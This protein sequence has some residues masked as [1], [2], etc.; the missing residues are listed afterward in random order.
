MNSKLVLA[1]MIAVICVAVTHGTPAPAPAPTRNKRSFSWLPSFLGGQPAAEEPTILEDD[2]APVA[3]NRIENIPVGQYPDA[4][5]IGPIIS[6]GRII[7]NQMHYPIWRI[8][9]YQ[10]LDARPLPIHLVQGGA[11][12]V[13]AQF[14]QVNQQIQSGSQQ[15]QITPPTSENRLPPSTVEKIES[16]L[17]PELIQM[18][19]SYGV[20]DFSNVPSLESAMDLLGTQT[21]EETIAAIKEFAATQE[22]RDLIRQFV[23]GQQ[24]DNEAA[25]SENVETVVAPESVDSTKAVANIDQEAAASQDAS[26]TQ[27]VAVTQDANAQAVKNYENMYASGSSPMYQYLLPWNQAELIAQYPNLGNQGETTNQFPLLGRLA[28]LGTEP[29]K[30]EAQSEDEE[31]E[32]ETTTPASFFGRVRQWT[33]FLNPFTGRQEIPIPPSEN[34]SKDAIATPVSANDE[35]ITN[36]NT[37]PIPE[38]PELPSLPSLPGAEQSPPE[39]PNVHIPIRY[40]PP[41]LSNGAIPRVGGPYV[42]VKLPLDGFN[43]TPQY[44]IE[45]Q[46]LNHARNQLQRQIIPGQVPIA[47]YHQVFYYPEGVQRPV[48]VYHR[49]ATTHVQPTFQQQP[50][51]VPAN[52]AP[53]NEAPVEVPT[54]VGAGQP[55]DFH[56][57]IYPEVSRQS[58]PS[59]PATPIETPKEQNVAPVQ[60][61]QSN[62]NGQPISSNLQVPQ[63]QPTQ[64]RTNPI[65][66][67]LPVNGQIQHVGQLPLVPSAN[68]EVFA[69]APR[70][71]DSYG[72]PAVPF[73]YFHDGK[74][75]TFWVS[76]QS[77]SAHIH[78]EYEVQPSA[79]GTVEYKVSADGQPQTED[80][81]NEE[82]VEEAEQQENEQEEQQPEEEQQQQVEEIDERSNDNAEITP[83][84]NQNNEELEQ[85]KAIDIAET[86]EEQEVEENVKTE[87]EVAVQQTTT[88]TESTIYNS[89]RPKVKK[90]IKKPIDKNVATPQNNRFIRH[91]TDLSNNGNLYRADSKTVELLPFNLRNVPQHQ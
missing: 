67:A 17:T 61:Q 72:A 57:Q 81:V 14:P 21:K 54:G 27:N 46:F 87:Q 55:I 19:R 52:E 74:P 48:N 51:I 58:V 12:N 75:N 6:N 62:S 44:A 60:V 34:E 1:A 59:T 91:S 16:W 24:Q 86:E 78:Q 88:S 45:P 8:H 37:V 63:I 9:K 64:F 5:L 50:I 26:V 23:E 71:Q 36:Q 33:S 40:T 84:A 56:K 73:Q 10:G 42:R 41:A 47:P 2:V 76:P 43:P 35:V 90:I 15:Q 39:L 4:N 30:T 7:N 13:V 28:T 3:D 31:A 49:V 29:A 89:L 32:V 69:N 77:N 18:A 11:G 20:K 70:I 22:G 68:Y 65:V 82:A 79:S 85:Q 53:V 38:L 80:D 25:A 83:D 66:P